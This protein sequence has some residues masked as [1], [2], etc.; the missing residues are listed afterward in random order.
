MLLQSEKAEFSAAMAK[1]VDYTTGFPDC[2][3]LHQIINTLCLAQHIL[4]SHEKIVCLLNANKVGTQE[5]N[6]RHVRIIRGFTRTAMA[7]Q[8]HAEDTTALVSNMIRFYGVFLLTGTYP[9]V[10]APRVQK[11]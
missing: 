1:G 6:R 3:R 5:E 11:I 7:L 4:I 2:Q 9:D 10:Q 8:K